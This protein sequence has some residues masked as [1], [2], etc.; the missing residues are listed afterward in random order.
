LFTA[1]AAA[2]IPER[3]FALVTVARAGQMPVPFAGPLFKSFLTVM[4]IGI[5]LF[6][7]K[8]FQKLQGVCSF[9]SWAISWAEF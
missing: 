6:Y 8:R 1:T 3:A 4:F 7:H 5:I 2:Q 9:V